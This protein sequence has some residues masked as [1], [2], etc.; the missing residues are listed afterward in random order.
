MEVGLSAKIPTYSGGLGVLA[1]DTLKAAA[2][3]HLP[4]VGVTLLTKH[5]YFFQEIDAGKQISEPMSWRIDDFLTPVDA[6]VTVKING[7]DVSVGCWKYEI[8]GFHDYKVPVYFLHTNFEENSEEAKALCHDLYGDGPDYR[9]SQEIVLGIGGVRM[10]EKLGYTEVDRY[11]MNEGHSALLAL[12]LESKLQNKEKVREQ[13]MF[14]THTPVPAGH[15][16]FQMDLVKKILAPELYEIL[17]EE[18][19]MEGQLNMTLLALNSS[20]YINGVAQKHAEISKTMFPNYPIHSITNGVHARTWV[21]APFAKLYDKYIHHWKEDPYSL[22]YVS[23]ISLSEIWEAHQAAKKRIIDYTNAHTNVGMDYDFFTLGWAR[24]FTEY[25]RPD[26]LFKDLDRLNQIADKHGPIQV[27]YGGKAH[28]KD[29][30]GQKLIAEIIKLG[31]NLGENLKLAYITN[32][33]MYLGQLMTAGVDT[34]L[35]TPEPPHEASGTSGMKC[36]LNG[37]P[38]LSV[39]DGWWIEG[40]IE[41]ETG[42][43]FPTPE[44]LYEVLDTKVMPLFYKDPDGWRQVMRKTIMLNGSFFNASRMVNEYIKRAY[45]NGEY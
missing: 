2:D 22:R 10:L 43:S 41:G 3:S 23:N 25:K 20:N 40:C 1:G 24:R 34:W 42:W 17:A 37:V 8:E 45:K 15:D 4:I 32:Y 11:H 38:H 33:D 26:F 7:E 31:E 13:C 28:P 39:R 14:T 35:N 6:K 9:L 16:K 27:I 19:H 12:E 5:G 21:S 44:D 29:E 36:A 30:G 18:Y